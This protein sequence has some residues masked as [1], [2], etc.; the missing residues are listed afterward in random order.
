[1]DCLHGLRIAE[2]IQCVMRKRV[3]R[4]VRDLDGRMVRLQ[5]PE[6]LSC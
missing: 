5:L 6:H 1:M 3:L 2:L 4:R